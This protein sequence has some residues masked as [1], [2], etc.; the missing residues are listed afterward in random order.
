MTSAGRKIDNKTV[1]KYIEAFCDSYILYKANRYDIKGK[2]ILK[3]QNKFFLVDLGIRRLLLGN[4]RSDHGKLL[5]NIVYLELLRRGYNIYIGKINDKEVDFI[6]EM[7][8][9]I[10]YY[11]IADTIRGEETFKRKISSLEAIN[12]N[13]PKYVLTR[14][15]ESSSHNGIK[16]LNVIDWLVKN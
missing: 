5:E 7:S 1:E 10:E 11:Q 9:G 6:A 8:E 13:Y 14:D 15:Y 4:K 16:I 2:E 12:D 3:T